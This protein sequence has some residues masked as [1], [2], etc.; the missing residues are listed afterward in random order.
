MNRLLVVTN[1]SAGSTDDERV[2]AALAV[3]RAAADVRVEACADPG[4]LDRVLDGLGRRGSLVVVGGDGSVHA[5]VATLRR[6]GELSPDR[7][8]GLVPLGTGN[9]LA[10][11]LGIPLE[12]ADGGPGAA[13]RPAAAPWTWSWTTPAAWSST[14]CTSGSGAEAAEQ[15][16]ALKE[17]LGKAAYAVGSVPAGCRP[18]PAGT[19]TSRSTAAWCTPTRRC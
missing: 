10:R 13:G 8:L 4:D 3:L 5:A 7:P 11:T 6:R 1:A 19:C 9:D 2:E 14:P 18:R 15:A 17:R 12:P 16:T